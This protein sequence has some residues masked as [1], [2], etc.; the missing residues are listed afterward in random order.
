LYLVQIATDV[1]RNEVTMLALMHLCI[2][3]LH[4]S[5]GDEEVLPLQS[6]NGANRIVQFCSFLAWEQTTLLNQYQL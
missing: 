2:V 1:F 6:G 5:K 4:V 3:Y